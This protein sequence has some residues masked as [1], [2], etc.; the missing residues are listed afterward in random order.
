M[1]QTYPDSRDLMPPWIVTKPSHR[2]VTIAVANTEYSLTFPEGT[3][4]FAMKVRG[5]LS[6]DTIRIAFESGKVATPTDPYGSFPANVEKYE[7]DMNLFG[8]L[9]IYFAC[10][11]GGKVVEFEIW[12]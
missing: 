7:T 3:K 12:Q 2:V 11:A 4:R 10:S 6:T 5:G 8:E 1:S 9:T